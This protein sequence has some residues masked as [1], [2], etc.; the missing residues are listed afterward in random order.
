M[1]RSATLQHP[2]EVVA[3]VDAS[4]NIVALLVGADG[5]LV[6]ES[7]LVPKNF[8]YISYTATNATTDTYVYKT[9]GS[10]GTTVATV[11]VVWTTAAHTVLASVTRT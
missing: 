10:G 5:T 4:G 1:P 9:G 11:A 2:P 3:G 7:G 8:D 6:T